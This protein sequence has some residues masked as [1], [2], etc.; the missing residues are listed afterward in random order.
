M[1][2]RSFYLIAI[3]AVMASHPSPARSEILDASTVT[4]QKMLDVAAL[5]PVSKTD[6]ESQSK[7]G[8][9]LIWMQGYQAPSEHGTAV[10]LKTIMSNID[11]IV[12]KCTAQPNLGLMT[13]TQK[14]WDEDDALPTTAV[15]LTTV[16]CESMMTSKDDDRAS[17]LIW[18][19][20]Y[21][22]FVAEDPTFD[23]DA[24]GET[25]TSIATYCTENPT[26][27]LVTASNKAGE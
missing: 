16:T 5:K 12:E 22:A 19:L 14:L 17:M 3:V 26:M 21:N 8:V 2:L 11:R 9:M 1:L 24:L 6:E 18:L 7:L 23:L 4:C 15:D 13:V 10:D 27:G 25:V 20:G